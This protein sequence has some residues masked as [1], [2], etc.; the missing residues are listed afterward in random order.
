MKYFISNLALEIKNNNKKINYSNSLIASAILNYF[1]P[2][3]QAPL[4][5]RQQ[6]K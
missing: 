4:G 1:G 2:D 5:T 6:I 3:F